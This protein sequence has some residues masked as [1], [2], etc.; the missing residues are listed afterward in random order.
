MFLAGGSRMMKLRFGVLAVA[1]APLLLAAGA[2]RWLALRGD[3]RAG[4]GVTTL[5]HKMLCA[6]LGLRVRVTGECA[7]S[8]AALVVA[9]HVSWLDIPAI[10][11]IGPIAFLA[12]K[13]VGRHWLARE[14]VKLQGIV[15]VDRRRKRDIPEVNRAIARKISRGT[16]VALFAEATT[17]DGAKLLRFR[18]SHFE[19]LRGAM[20]DR[21]GY[22][23]VQP[24]FIAYRSR[25]GLPLGRTGQPAVAWYGD[26]TFASHFWRILRDGPFEC[27]IAFGEPIR[28]HR[29]SNRKEIALRTENVVRELAAG[30]RRDR[31]GGQ[32]QPASAHAPTRGLRAAKENGF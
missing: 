7:Q 20:S 30:R 6:A 10:A 4:A 18:S 5:F 25:N 27:E 19:A 14:I 13:E 29:T 12:K 22:A 17:G 11:S 24:V 21:T 3:W 31:L 16:P 26:M 1:L 9:N 32:A 8:G 28:F 23:M 15:F 2:L